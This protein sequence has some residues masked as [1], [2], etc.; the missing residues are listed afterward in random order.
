MDILAVV[1]SLFVA[2]LWATNVVIH[3]YGMNQSINPK[4]IVVLAG[5]AY[6]ISIVC[7]AVYHYKEL[8]TDIQNTNTYTIAIIAIGAFLGLFIGNLLF[9]NLLEKQNS[10]L[11]TTIAYTT[12][13]FVLLLALLFLKNE[14]V[15]GIQMLGI[16]ITVIGIMIICHK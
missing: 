9:I 12:P 14:K 2:F 16:L 7:F 5:F 10:S 13:L 6:F 1:L 3:K 11:V 15:T 8:Y 4:T